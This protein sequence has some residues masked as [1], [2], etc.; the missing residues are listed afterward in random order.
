MSAQST[1]ADGRSGPLGVRRS[2]C[3]MTETSHFVVHHGA[4]PPPAALAGAVVAIGN[5]DGVHRGHRAVIAAALA[6]APVARPAG[7]GADLRA[8]SAQLLPAAGAAV[9][10]H[11]RA[12]QAAPVRGHRARPARSCSS[13]TPRWRSPR[14]RISSTTSCCIGSASPAPRSASIS[15]SGKNR[16]GTPDLLAAEGARRSFAVD[17]VP[18]VEI[19]RTADLLRRRSARRSPPA[20]SREA[21]ELLGYPWFVSGEVVHGDKRGRELGYPTANLRLDPACGLRHGIYAVRVG[22]G[23]RTLRRRREFRPAADVRRRHGAARSV[24]VR[25]FR[26]PLRPDRSTSPSSTGSGPS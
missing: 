12:R 5:F 2:A 24:P 16:A 8:A 15:A 21:N 1:P 14:R 9:P 4:A 23:G 10:A 19:E 11:R 26:R 18:A 20:A 17:V 3:A 25:F 22:V 7:R 13:S 6:R